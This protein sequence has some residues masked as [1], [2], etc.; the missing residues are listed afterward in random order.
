MAKTD[1]KAEAAEAE[2][3]R[4]LQHDTD[5]LAGAGLLPESPVPERFIVTDPEPV[6]GLPKDTGWQRSLTDPD[7]VVSTTDNRRY[8]RIRE[9]DAETGEPTGKES[10]VEIVEQR[11]GEDVEEGK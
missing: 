11:G 9:L 1:E 2:R 6:K 7:V 8:R 5:T 4:A 3:Q 10:Y